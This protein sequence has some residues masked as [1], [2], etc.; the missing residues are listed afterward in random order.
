[1]FMEQSDNLPFDYIYLFFFIDEARIFK[2]S[3]K[4]IA[5]KERP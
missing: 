5:V 1:M 2:S 3:R 4:V